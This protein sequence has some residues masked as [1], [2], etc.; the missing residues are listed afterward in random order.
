[1]E[2]FISACSCPAIRDAASIRKSCCLLYP[3]LRSPQSARWHSSTRRPQRKETPGPGNSVPGKL[4]VERAEKRKHVA[5]EGDA[6]RVW[7]SLSAI[8]PRR[9]SSRPGASEGPPPAIRRAV[10]VLRRSM[11]EASIAILKDSRNGDV[12]SARARH[13]TSLHHRGNGA[14]SKSPAEPRAIAVV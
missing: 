2:N 8:R 6:G 14:V 3:K 10:P 9:Q 13:F 7:R 12:S 4:L 11:N 1:M 5:L